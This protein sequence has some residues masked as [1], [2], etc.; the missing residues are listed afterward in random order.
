MDTCGAGPIDRATDRPLRCAV[1][2]PDGATVESLAT[3]TMNDEQIE[4]LTAGRALNI[5]RSPRT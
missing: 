2:T 4:W 1:H 3:H 5:I